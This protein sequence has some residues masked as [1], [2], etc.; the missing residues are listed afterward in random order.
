MNGQQVYA[1]RAKD[2]QNIYA[3]IMRKKKEKKMQKLNKIP[4]QNSMDHLCQGK[5]CYS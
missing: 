2:K 1:S 4:H 3:R 5:V